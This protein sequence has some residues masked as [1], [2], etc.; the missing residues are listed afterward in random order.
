MG[1]LAKKKAAKKKTA[2]KKTAG[3]RG[4][5]PLFSEALA[6]EVCARLATGETV[7]SIC[8]DPKMP[9]YATLWKWERENEEFSLQSARARRRGTH[10]LADECI[11]IADDPTLDP[12]DKRIRVDTRIRLIGKWNQHDYGDKVSVDAKV[13]KVEVV[14]GGEDE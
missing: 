14:I 5:P 4:R 8:D 6:D 10:A 2:K 11:E 3:K 13:E 7:R 9:S 12:Q 1:K